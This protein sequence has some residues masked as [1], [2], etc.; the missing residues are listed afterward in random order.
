[1]TS[2]LVHDFPFDRPT[3]GPS[4]ICSS[5]PGPPVRPRTLD[6]F[7][8]AQYRAALE[9]APEPQVGRLV[10]ERDVRVFEVSHASVGGVRVSGWLVPPAEGPAEHGPS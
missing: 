8:R 9:V 10:E 7:W 2:T 1:M 5:I 4:T 6:D 3:G